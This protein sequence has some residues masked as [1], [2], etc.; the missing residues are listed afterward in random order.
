MTNIDN[1]YHEFESR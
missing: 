1:G